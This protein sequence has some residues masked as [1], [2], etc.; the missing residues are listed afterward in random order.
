MGI[1]EFYQIRS[2]LS[3]ND[4]TLFLSIIPGDDFVKIV[5]YFFCNLFLLKISL[6]CV[7]FFLSKNFSSHISIKI[8]LHHLGTIRPFMHHSS[9]YAPFVRLCTIRPFVHHSSVYAPFV[10]LCTIRLFMHQ[11]AVYAPFG[12]LQKKRSRP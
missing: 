3:L 7:R 6:L 8:S 9:I 10:R 1:W 2:F 12:R 11:S 4:S 5:S